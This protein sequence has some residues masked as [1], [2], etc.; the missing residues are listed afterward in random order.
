M[1]CTK[2]LNIVGDIASI[3]TVFGGGYGLYT[4]CKSRWA[5]IRITEYERSDQCLFMIVIINEGP[6]DAYNVKISSASR[7]KIETSQYI[8]KLQPGEAGQ[9]GFAFRGTTKALPLYLHWTDKMGRHKKKQVITLHT[10]YEF[11][12]K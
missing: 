5:K 12:D 9:I 4:W 2:I 11:T 6:A 10:I 8:S 1:D 7:Y 3:I